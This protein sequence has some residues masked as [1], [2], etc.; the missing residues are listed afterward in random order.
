MIIKDISSLCDSL[1]ELLMI[2]GQIPQIR[3]AVLDLAV[4]GRLVPEC[5]DAEDAAEYLSSVVHALEDEKPAKK[6][7]GVERP[8]IGVSV[9]E[10]W[11]PTM[12]GCIS[13]DIRYGTSLKTS[14]SGEVPVLRMGN[15]QK[16]RLEFD[17][18]KYLPLT[19]DLKH[20]MLEHGDILF[21]RT[22]SA[23]LV[24]K[25]AVFHGGG[26]FTFASYLIRVRLHPDVEPDFVNLWL[27]SSAGREWAN[28]VKTDAISQ[29]NINGTSLGQFP[30]ALPSRS[31]QVRIVE[32]VEA[33]LSLIDSFEVEKDE[34]AAR[35][36]AT[37]VAAC[38]ALVRRREKLLLDHADK[39]IRTSEDVDE[40]ERTI[41]GLAVS[42]QLVPQRSSD[43]DGHALVAEFAESSKKK[44]LAGAAFNLLKDPPFPIPDSW[45]WTTLG[46]AGNVVGGGTPRS[47]Q[48]GC[49]TYDPS[50]GLP[51]FTPADL[52]GNASMYAPASRRFL[53]EAGLKSCSA[54]PL[55]AGS[56]LFSSRAPIGYV[57]ILEQP[58]S[59]NQGFKSFVPRRGLVS[60]FVYFWLRYWAPEIDAAAPS[61]TFREANKK[62]MERQPIPVPPVEEQ[63]RIVDRVVQLMAVVRSL[64]DHIAA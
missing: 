35:R 29:S 3:R 27:G 42:G 31:E 18:L 12:L 6:L 7:K 51:W 52:G 47:G 25:S 10:T 16:Q 36:R 37:T 43:F 48:D 49:F 30:L 17:K 62:A 26:P 50:L 39:L 13:T 46:V 54:Q 44:E 28:R 15:I 61:V 55:P 57:A 34:L 24:G 5:D 58:A 11:A 1:S 32:R 45:A 63:H 14:D 38:N 53:T 56:V 64:R 41:F 9:P 20:L 19:P 40:V 23:A 60:E 2:P 21:N 22:N 4:S 33:I 59:T 8:Q